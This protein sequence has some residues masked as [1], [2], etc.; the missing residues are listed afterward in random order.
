MRILFKPS[1]LSSL[2]IIIHFFAVVIDGYLFLAKANS[3]PQDAFCLIVSP[4]IVYNLLNASKVKL[5]EL[6]GLE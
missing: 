2:S 5:I 4:G 1:G 3:S 6:S